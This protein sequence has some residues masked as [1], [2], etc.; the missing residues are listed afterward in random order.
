M[1]TICNDCQ[2]ENILQQATILVDLQDLKEPDF[3]LDL[4]GIFFDDYYYC[5]DC[6]QEVRVSE[7]EE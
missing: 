5:T 1:R 6:D 3:H 4:G 7:V 2:G